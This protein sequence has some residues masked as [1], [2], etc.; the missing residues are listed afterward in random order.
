M[1]I[2]LIFLKLMK[3]LNKNIENQLKSKHGM[4][5]Y[6]KNLVENIQK[7]KKYY[8][9]KLRLINL[10]QKVILQLL[11]LIKLNIVKFINIVAQIK[12]INFIVGIMK[13]K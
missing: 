8:N 7:M 5:H 3:K 12:I 2:A 11:T 1:M 6:K 13:P 4:K 10:S 9:K